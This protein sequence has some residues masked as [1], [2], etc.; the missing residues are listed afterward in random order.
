MKWKQLILT[1]KLNFQYV[2]SFV[3]IGSDKFLESMISFLNRMY[4]SN[5]KEITIGFRV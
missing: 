1:R 3:V 5:K 4:I 2:A